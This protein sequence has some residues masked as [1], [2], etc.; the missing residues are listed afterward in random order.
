MNQAERFDEMD[1]MSSWAQTQPV[2]EPVT[3]TH[4]NVAANDSR[5]D[6]YQHALKTAALTGRLHYV[7]RYG[8]A[9]LADSFKT[10]LCCAVAHPDGTLERIVQGFSLAVAQRA[11]R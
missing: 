4:I 11:V 3:L 5:P 8:D 2:R 9:L 7:N 6:P 10:R 1:S